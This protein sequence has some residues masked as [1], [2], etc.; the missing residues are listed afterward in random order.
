MI[1]ETTK[2]DNRTGQLRFQD[3]RQVACDALVVSGQL[4]PNAELLVE[5]GIA[6]KPPFHIPLMGSR[7]HLSSSGCFAVGNLLGGFHGGQWC[8]F[9]GRRLA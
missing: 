7:G 9:S 1:L 8:Y 6:T 5:A 4:V 3:G 2:G